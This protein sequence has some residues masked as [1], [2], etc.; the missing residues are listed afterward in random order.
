MLLILTHENADFDAVAAQ[1]GAHKLYPEGVPLLSWRINRNVNQFLTLYWDA[2]AFVRP[3]DWVRKK[4]QRVVLVDMASLPSVRGIR[5][6]RV[7]VQ[8]IDHHDD[9]GDHNENWSYHVAQVGATST[10]LVE[11]L[12]AAG[13]KLSP[14]EATLLLLGI[15]EDTG[16]LVYDTTT[17][18]D[19]QAASWL[20]DQGAQVS[21]VRRF[22]NIA[23]SNQQQQLY[24][25]L[26]EA[27]EW[28]TIQG[29]HLAI[30]SVKA[31]DGFD[32]E[33][34]AV[35]HR[36]RDT[37]LPD[38]LYLLVQL[39]QN[40]IQLVSR[41]G[42]A[43]VDVS[44]IAKALGGGGHNRAAAATIMDQDIELVKERILELLP[45]SVQPMVKVSQIMSYGVQ[46]VLS[47]TS[48]QEAAEL[49]QRFGHEGYPVLDP[50]N[51]ELVGLLTRRIVDRAMSHK[52]KQLPVSQI[53][54]VGSV[55]IKASDSINYVRRLMI[56]EG[57]GQI[58]VVEEKNGQP[59][60]VI[61]IVTRTDL[62][63]LFND[64]VEDSK[65]SDVRQQMADSLPKILWRL[66]Q[67]VSDVA[68]EMN[69]PLYFV[70]G[71]VRDLLLA[72]SS[73]DIDMVVEGDAIALVKTLCARYGGDSRSHAQFGTAKWLLLDSTWKKIAPELS[74]D[75][76]PTAIDFV[77]A[78]SE[79][80][81]SPTAL[82]EVER[83]SIK[84]DLHRRDFTINTLAI[85]LDGAHLGQLLD[86]YG[87]QRDLESGIIRVLHS[88]SFIDDPTR[89]LRAARLEQRLGFTIE[90]RTNELITA[91]IP[92]LDRVTGDRIRHELEMCLEEAEPV[93][94]FD[95]LA[96]LNV[97][98]Q[99]HPS[100][101]WNEQA[102]VPFLRVDALLSEFEWAGLNDITR[103]FVFFAL[104]MLSHS[105][106]IWYQT[107][108]RLKVRR[109]TREDL[110]SIRRLLESQDSFTINSRPS[111][112]VKKL[113]Q[114]PNRVLFT[115]SAK[116][117]P[118]ET[119][120]QAIKKYQEEWRQI[121]TTLDGNDL[122][123][124][125]LEPGPEIGQLLDNLLDA[126][127][128]GE[129]TNEAGERALVAEFIDRRS[130][131]S[132][133]TDEG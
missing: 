75:D 123:E 47:T 84:L 131:D 109:T 2:F 110:S 4:V 38:G 46:T 89:I 23:L 10:I 132:T 115:A 53:M 76:A 105:P 48:V 85:R 33:I 100:L 9:D 1:L 6:D 68:S 101:T 91:A 32:D 3:E 62:I 31:P 22:L 41:S 69:M 82:P 43:Y 103:V 74:I 116:A 45:E 124:E 7:Q 14:N 83:G 36:L 88:L 30:A 94:I 120:T 59:S 8:V 96:S 128:D 16:S 93:P 87:G 114:Y 51:H 11:M 121:R 130:A 35:A 72:K 50:K 40:H 133:S 126:R 102:A 28:I 81:T 17:A 90:S 78:R 92:M 21:V 117:G 113:R 37:L 98:S 24:Q 108:E 65:K 34:S 57:W 122:R 95:R 64:E 26:Q 39:K 19:A 66:V 70:G 107:I 49:M 56:D 104:W 42:S 55:T 73:S 63:A 77:T 44:L 106:A 127:L 97:L 18:R 119:I 111:T 58:P 125:G 20:L 5:A 71:L 61:G 29:Q 60:T 15:H 12:Q 86:F 129:I 118:K 99:I 25:M 52:L 112:L 80:Y 67:I 54:K 13:L 27:A 79:F